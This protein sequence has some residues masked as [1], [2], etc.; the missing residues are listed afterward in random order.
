MSQP[1]NVTQG[2]IHLKSGTYPRA[3]NES[4]AAGDENQRLPPTRDAP[5]VTS[6]SCCTTADPETSVDKQPD[7]S[8]Q[9]E[10]VRRKTLQHYD[11]ENSRDSDFVN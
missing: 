4:T 7:I 9:R 5:V 10:V 2:Q 6:D 11:F 3:E 8:E 1:E